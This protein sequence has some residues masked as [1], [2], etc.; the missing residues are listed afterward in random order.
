MSA[1]LVVSGVVGA[2]V[3]IDATTVATHNQTLTDTAKTLWD[4]IEDMESPPT[5]LIDA[6]DDHCDALRAMRTALHM[7]TMQ[8]TT[9]GGTKPG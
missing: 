2:P 7:P 1:S 8:P 5:G 4:I 3:N 9:P 6:R